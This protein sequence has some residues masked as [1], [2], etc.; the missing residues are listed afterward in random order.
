[1]IRN[2][3]RTLA[4]LLLI[5]TVA[6]TGYSGRPDLVEVRVG[7]NVFQGRV[8]AHNTSLFWLL[9]RDGRMRRLRMDSV[10]RFR[11]VTPRFRGF[12]AVDVKSALRRE[13]GHGY[14]V[15]STQHY[16]VVASPGDAKK[17]AEQFEKVYRTFVNYFGVRKFPIEK[18]KFPLVAVVFPDRA[19]FVKYARKDGVRIASRILGYYHPGSNRVALFD[20]SRTT[21]GRIEERTIGARPIPGVFVRPSGIA[22]FKDTIVHEGTHQ[23]AFNTG[24]HTRIGPTPRWLVEGLATVFEAPGI[25]NRRGERG[26]TSRINPARFDG[27]RRYVAA[28]RKRGSLRQLIAGDSGITRNIHNFYAEAWALSYFLL[29]TRSQNYSKYLRIVS[30]RDPLKPY[31]ARDRTADFQQAFGTNIDRLERDFLRFMSRL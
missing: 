14:A 2:L 6:D 27:F 31:P 1:M 4:F 8:V 20:D 29:E 16:V 28:G 9:Q 3:C 10:S 22:S 26:A 30:G 21:L 15:V 17:F 23:V 12:R 19:Q 7:K 25:R 18:P 13:F 11:S 5:L 24:L